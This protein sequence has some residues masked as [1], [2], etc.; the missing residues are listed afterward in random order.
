MHIQKHVWIQIWTNFKIYEN[1]LFFLN[2]NETKSSFHENMYWITNHKSNSK[3]I[4]LDNHNQ[5]DEQLT[6]LSE[7]SCVLPNKYIPGNNVINLVQIT[8]YLVVQP[9]WVACNTCLRCLQTPSF[10]L[11]AWCS[12]NYISVPLVPSLFILK[13]VYINLTILDH[14]KGDLNSGVIDPIYYLDQLT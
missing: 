2:S 6:H 5:K 12:Y 14:K 4:F 3:A 11:K 7:S 1:M 13:K 8:I 10:T 9:N